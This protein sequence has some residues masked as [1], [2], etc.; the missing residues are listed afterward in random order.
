VAAGLA[1]LSVRASTCL[2][3][4]LAGIGVALFAA[5]AAD[6]NAQGPGYNVLAGLC[7]FCSIGCAIAVLGRADPSSST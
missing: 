6:P 4:A 3:A 1:W 5:L 2:L 7:D